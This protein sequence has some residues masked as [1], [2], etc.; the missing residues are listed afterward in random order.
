MEDTN[1]NGIPDTADRVIGL[2]LAAVSIVGGVFSLA[3]DPCP[4]WI[5]PALASLAALASLFTVGVVPRPGRS[6]SAGSGPMSSFLMLL[7]LAVVLGGCTPKLTDGYRSY[8]AASLAGQGAEK[9]VLGTCAAKLDVCRGAHKSASAELAA[10]FTTCSI[11]ASGDAG[12][13]GKC[14][15]ELADGRI[16]L[17]KAYRECKKLCMDAVRHWSRHIAPS[18]N[19]ALAVFWAALE[20]ARIAGKKD[21]TLPEKAKPGLCALLKAPA[22]FEHL[23]GATLK[24]ILTPIFALK[25]LVCK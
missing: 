24:A 23:F 18:Y 4:V 17:V 5:A 7:G 21:Y 11:K 13:L 12:K 8:G 10:K 14:N 6:S 1:R 22:Y 2:V 19:A 15:Q 20:T 3:L 9:I 25:G 16:G